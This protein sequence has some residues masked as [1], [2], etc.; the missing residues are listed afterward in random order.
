MQ[1]HNFDNLILSINNELKLQCSMA[2][3]AFNAAKRDLQI[4]AER[5]KKEPDNLTDIDEVRQYFEK[6]SEAQHGFFRNV[7]SFIVCHANISKLFHWKGNG[8]KGQNK[9]PGSNEEKEKIKEHLQFLRQGLDSFEDNH[10]ELRDHIEHFDE[11]LINSAYISDICSLSFKHSTSQNERA[12][13]KSKKDYLREIVYDQMI[14]SVRG[15]DYNLA[16]M[17]KDVMKL[18]NGLETAS[19][20][21]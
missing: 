16:I 9:F 13:G 5:S 20:L 11:R 18:K 8:Y 17:V 12:I 19:R 1:A 14:Y 10:R 21:F 2:L 15:I 4:Y 3:D 7:H 6:A